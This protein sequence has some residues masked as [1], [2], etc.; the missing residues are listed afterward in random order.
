MELA[1]LTPDQYKVLKQIGFPINTASKHPT[2]TL[3]FV[4]KWLREEKKVFVIVGMDETSYPKFCATVKKWK[5]VSDFEKLHDFEYVG[6][7][8]D[9]TYEGAESTGLDCA[10]NYLFYQK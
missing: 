1:R 8:L 9:R 7:M 3:A 10:L 2:P 4:L 5:D 6:G